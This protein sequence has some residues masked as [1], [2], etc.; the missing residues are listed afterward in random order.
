M[1]T[2]TLARAMD[3]RVSMERYAELTPAWNNALLAADCTSVLRV[4]MWC[5]QIGHES[6]GLKW[7]EEIADGSGYEGR[8]DLGNTQPG[9]GKR[10]KGRGPIQ[11]TGRYNYRK[12]SAW[13]RERGFV[14]RDNVFENEPHLLADPHW[15]FL[16][17]T[18]YWTVARNMNAFADNR[19]LIGATRAVNGG[20][21][22]IDDRRKFYY[23]ALE[24][25]DALLPTR[26]EPAVSTAEE[27]KNQLTGSPVAGEYP[28]WPQLG[29][30]TVVDALAD[31]RDVLTQP[32]ESLIVGEKGPVSFDFV[33]YVKFI[34]AA[35]YRTERAAERIEAALARIE[36][37]LE[38]K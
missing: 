36:K 2:A 29:N 11:L 31:V 16:A 19:D 1:D 8:A 24:L 7:M 20:Q 15:G 33:T 18:Y 32:I 6:G 14:D 9:D 28:G 13:A 17:A 27:V 35:A 38:G 37:K 5:S 26:E 25:G 21:N 12:F 3:N 30:Q 34:D 23:R 22:G 4:T 10:F